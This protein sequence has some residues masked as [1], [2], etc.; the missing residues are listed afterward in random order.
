M[1]RSKIFFLSAEIYPFVKDSRA[2]E[3]AGSL[4]SYLQA[5]GHEVRVMMPK[6]SLI[7]ER[8]YIIRD[9]IRLKDIPVQMPGGTI[10]VSVKSGFLPETK[11]QIYFAD[12]DKFFRRSDVYRDKRTGQFFKDN[13]LRYIG[14]ARA[15]LATLR[16]L[17]WQPD[18]IHC[19]DWPTGFLPALLRQEQLTDNFFKKTVLVFSVN[20]LD[21]A[22]LHPK[23]TFDLGLLSDK[24]VDRDKCLHKGKFSFLKAGVMHS[25]AV[26]VPYVYKHLK[27]INKPRNDFEQ[28]MASL[29][30]I[31][32]IPIG[33]DHNLWNPAGNNSLHKPYS[34]EKY[35][36]RKVNRE[37]FLEEKRT[38]FAVDRPVIGILCEDIVAQQKDLAQFLKALRSVPLQFFLISDQPAAGLS[39]LKSALKNSAHVMYLVHDPD[40]AMRHHFYMMSDAVFIP[41][42]SDLADIH[43]MN[44]LHYGTIP[45]MRKHCTVAPHFTPVRGHKGT[46]FFFADDK[47][48]LLRFDELQ[49]LFAQAES[50]QS[51][52]LQAM[53]TDVS[54]SHFI[55]DIVKVYDRA[56]SKVR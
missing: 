32:D 46:A 49:N 27:S 44:A 12:H 1:K 30:N 21:E 17:G 34:P 39:G 5:L 18:I 9:I 26:T 51:L 45:L 2:G 11:T 41:D 33:G 37:K 42:G 24:T 6:Y 47:E 29:K 38:G 14:L 15:A 19:C 20:M 48:L 16:Q 22:G 43:Y 52:V 13:D 36:R 3:F 10:H 50:W 55:S 35:E 56:F 53:K 4:P 28:I 31:T 23:G 54:W 25:D 8:K 40:D 7:N